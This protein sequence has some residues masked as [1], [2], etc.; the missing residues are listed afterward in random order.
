M[1]DDLRPVYDAH[2]VFVAPTRYAAGIPYK[3]HE[4]ASYGLP[5]VATELLARQLE[6]R[7]GSDLTVAR[8]GDPHAFAERVVSLYRDEAQWRRL[9]ENALNRLRAENS[10]ERYARDV[11]G[12]LEGE[13]ANTV[14]P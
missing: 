1:V 7:D 6:W 8:N 13:A 3:V 9:R 2:R 12:L 4:A 14:R 5:V 10:R 11:R